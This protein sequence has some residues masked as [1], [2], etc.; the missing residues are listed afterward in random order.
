LL[1]RN[2]CI[3][4]T[5]HPPEKS[6]KKQATN[7]RGCLEAVGGVAKKFGAGIGRLFDKV[8]PDVWHE[9]GYVTMLSYSLL[10]PR[11]E[12]VVDRGADEFLPIVLVHGLGENR[13]AW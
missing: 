6:S 5:T 11:R 4:H 7:D 2:F 10:L 3:Y 9:L 1:L 8:S 13:G 12:H